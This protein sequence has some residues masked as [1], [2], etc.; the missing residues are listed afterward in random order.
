MPR[1][2]L[3]FAALLVALA[4][5]AFAGVCDDE[6]E[7]L[8]ALAD[9]SEAVR[10]ADEPFTYALV[11]ADATTFEAT[12]VRTGSSVWVGTLSIDERGDLTGTVRYGEAGDVIAPT[13]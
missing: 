6:E 11:A 1:R 3:V 4:T 13:D 7:A 10:A 8:E 12:A 9:A 5:P 2:A